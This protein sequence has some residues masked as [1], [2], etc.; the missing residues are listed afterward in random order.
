MCY[1]DTHIF[2]RSIG[3][4][5]IIAYKFLFSLLLI[6]VS[7]I[8]PLNVFAFENANDVRIDS[9][10]Q[11]DY[12]GYSI[13]RF[14]ISTFSYQIVP[15]TQA[16]R[17]AGILLVVALDN[18]VHDYHPLFILRAGESSLESTGFFVY[19]DSI[20][21][22]SPVG[23]TTIFCRSSVCYGSG[24]DV[25]FFDNNRI[26][27]ERDGNW[28]LYDPLSGA[29]ELWFTPPSPDPINTENCLEIRDS[30]CY[31]LEPYS[32]TKQPASA[33][34]SYYVSV[35]NGSLL[36]SSGMRLY[37]PE[38]FVGHWVAAPGVDEVVYENPGFV[39]AN[40][41]WVN[42][43]SRTIPQHPDFLNATSVLPGGA[44]VGQINE[45]VYVFQ[46]NRL[47]RLGYSYRSLMEGY[48][49]VRP[50]WPTSAMAFGDNGVAWIGTN[51]ALYVAT[52]DLS[53]LPATLIQDIPTNVP[54]RFQSQPTVYIKLSNK[55]W[56]L[57][58]RRFDT[59]AEY[60]S[61]FSDP[62]FSKVVVVSDN[63]YDADGWLTNTWT[64][65]CSTEPENCK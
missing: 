10:R 24:A 50:A 60:Q 30:V 16:M 23:N 44:V 58:S 49:L 27:V 65:S 6:L 64:W 29:S 57:T 53:K 31:V 42:L 22:Y 12:Q 26:V 5:V 41:T 4:L 40:N 21:T 32:G 63:P 8:Q 36:F 7:V 13:Q 15:G 35:L 34:S 20:G 3:A 39:Y 59:A 43:D 47:T 25:V 37:D 55:D 9:D 54:F 62:T 33:T 45:G 48:G 18:E 46:N 38:H 11:F 52:L 61:E 2:G 51:G 17:D 28:Y 56:F 19:L 1:R 14:P